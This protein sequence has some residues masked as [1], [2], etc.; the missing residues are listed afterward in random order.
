V[1]DFG[2]RPIHWVKLSTKKT[3]ENKFSAVLIFK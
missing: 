2:V 3:A 1:Q